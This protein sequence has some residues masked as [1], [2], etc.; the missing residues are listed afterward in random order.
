LHEQ[1]HHQVEAEDTKGQYK[2]LS[3][4]S[5]P[6]SIEYEM[7]DEDDEYQNFSSESIPPM[8]DNE[9]KVLKSQGHSTESITPISYDDWVEKSIDHFFRSIEHSKANV[10]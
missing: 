4:Q 10:D 2:K 1:V 3:L 8:L 5:Q 7:N 6:C 9:L